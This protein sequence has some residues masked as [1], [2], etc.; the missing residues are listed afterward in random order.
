MNVRP[1]LTSVIATAGF[2]FWF[3]LELIVSPEGSAA[4]AS[5]ADGKNYPQA[6]QEPSVLAPSAATALS[7]WLQY[8]TTGNSIGVTHTQGLVWLKVGA[9]Y[10]LKSA[11]NLVSA[12]VAQRGLHARIFPWSSIIFPMSC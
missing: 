6:A 11:T 9:D 1:Q 3:R 5:A 4:V 2:H 8:K 10:Y 12:K 7:I